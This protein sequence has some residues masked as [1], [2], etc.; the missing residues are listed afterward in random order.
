LT[1]LNVSRTP[2]VNLDPLRGAPL[3]ELSL[4]GCEKLQ[5]VEPLRQCT[6]LERLVVPQRVGNLATLRTLP[7]LRFLSSDKD[8][9]GV[10][11]QTAQQFWLA[12]GGRSAAAQEM[13]SKGAGRGKRP[14]VTR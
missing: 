10:Y 1:S 3:V 4:A 12:E 6:D 7:S 9:N 2:I 13:E 11:E 14:S 5:S 8:G